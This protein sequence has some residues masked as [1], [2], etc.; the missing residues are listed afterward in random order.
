MFLASAAVSAFVL[1]AISPVL[2]FLYNISPFHP[3]YRYPGPRAWTGSRLLWALS[4]RKGN[5]HNDLKRF[6]ER[7]GSIVRIAPNELSYIDC[8]AW[9]DIY[10]TS[11]STSST[12]SGG[13]L[14]PRNSLW[15]NDSKNARPTDPTSIMGSNE[16]SHARYRKAFMPAFTDKAL[17]TQDPILEVNVNGFIEQLRKRAD[18]GETVNIID[19]L[20][21]LSFDISGELSF[22]ETFGSVANGKAHP[23]VEININVGC[24][25]HGSITHFFVTDYSVNADHISSAKAPLSW[26]H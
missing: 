20:N 15:F 3:L 11:P 19:W 16:E 9:R 13:R 8:Q 24:F 25:A 26:P 6:H 12:S 4:M 22:G 17:Q 1:L 14:F 23:W 2:I 5:L 21:Y 18:A 7:Y 10:L